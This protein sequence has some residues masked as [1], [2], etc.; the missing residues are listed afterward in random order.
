MSR[1][2]EEIHCPII[3]LEFGVGE[4]DEEMQKQRYTEK[5]RG[6]PGMRERGR[7]RVCICV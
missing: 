7:L 3:R 5:E 4:L 1:T 6:L 2:G